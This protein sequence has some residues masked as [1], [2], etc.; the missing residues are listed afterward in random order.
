M[1]RTLLVNNVRDFDVAKIVLVKKSREKTLSVDY[2]V[3]VHLFYN[4]DAILVFE[5]RFSK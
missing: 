5:H 4:I 3:R 1:S 2:E